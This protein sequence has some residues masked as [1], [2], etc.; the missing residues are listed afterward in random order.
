MN[1]EKRTE[2]AWIFMNC[3]WECSFGPWNINLLKRWTFTIN[4]YSFHLW[5]CEGDESNKTLHWDKW[6]LKHLKINEFIIGKQRIMWFD[7]FFSLLSDNLNISRWCLINR[8]LNAIIFNIFVIVAFWFMFNSIICLF[9]QSRIVQFFLVS[10]HWFCSWNW[11]TF[12]LI[13]NSAFN[14]R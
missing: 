11:N 14:V 13:Y 9:S 4:Y 10:S 2:S 12:W 6:C 8:C 7:S 1:W 3:W 5:I